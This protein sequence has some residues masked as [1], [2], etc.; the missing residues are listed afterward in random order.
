MARRKPGNRRKK[1]AATGDMAAGALIL[2]DLPVL[3][4][5]YLELKEEE[6]REL[7]K[8][9]LRS[10]E[11]LKGVGLHLGGNVLV[12]PR[13][14]VKE[15]ERVIREVRREYKRF[16]Q[17]VLTPRLALVA[18]TRGQMAKVVDFVAEDVVEQL[19]YTSVRVGDA[20]IKARQTSDEGELQ[21]LKKEVLVLMEDW[22]SRY[23]IARML[24][25]DLDDQAQELE[26]LAGAALSHLSA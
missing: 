5:D 26:E 3:P 19:E 20:L 2:H 1:Q 22:R 21:K 8:S 11:L 16:P 17:P 24:G 6:R 4:P 9:N 15:A 18:L 25:I 7:E 13:Q 14:L 12:V 23:R 10:Y